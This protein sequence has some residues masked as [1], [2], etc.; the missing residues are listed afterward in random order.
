MYNDRHSCKHMDKGSTCT[1]TDK[2]SCIDPSTYREEQGTCCRTAGIALPQNDDTVYVALQEVQAAIMVLPFDAYQDLFTTV[3]AEIQ[4][5]CAQHAEDAEVR[6]LAA[7]SVG[8]R[9]GKARHRLLLCT[10]DVSQSRESVHYVYLFPLRAALGHGR[11]TVAGF[12]VKEQGLY[13]EYIRSPS[14]R[15]VSALAG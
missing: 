14:W 3:H 1:H 9:S 2:M 7:D 10:Q 6:Q 15:F 4:R 11:R 12:S 5:R 13:T 8:K